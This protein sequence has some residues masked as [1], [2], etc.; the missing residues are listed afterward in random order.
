ML[1]NEEVLVVEEAEDEAHVELADY[2]EVLEILLLYW[3]GS[4]V[5]F[6][7]YHYWLL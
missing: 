1:V 7:V 4:C 6:A 2:F 3:L 5:S